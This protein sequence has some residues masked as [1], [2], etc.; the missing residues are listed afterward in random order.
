MKSDWPFSTLRMFGYGAILADPP[1]SYEMYSD[2]GYGKSPEAHYDT[3][4]DDDIA[5]L[6]DRKSVV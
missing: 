4:S 3:M 5:A 2:K 6:P 1:W